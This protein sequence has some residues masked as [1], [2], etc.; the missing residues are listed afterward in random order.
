MMTDKVC[1]VLTTS[2]DFEYCKEQDCAWWNAE[3]GQCAVATIALI[4]G[5]WAAPSRLWDRDEK[6]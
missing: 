2:T 1:P 6:K 3:Y 4:A 5:L